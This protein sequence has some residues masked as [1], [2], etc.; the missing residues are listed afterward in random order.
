VERDGIQDIDQRSILD[1]KVFDDIEG[2]DFGVAGDG[3]WKVPSEGWSGPSLTACS[4]EG[5]AAFEDTSNGPD[6][7]DPAKL[8]LEQFSVNSQGSIL[9]E[10]TVDLQGSSQV[11]DPVF[12]VG[13]GSVDGTGRTC[14]VGREIDTVQTLRSRPPDPMLDRGQAEA[15]LSGYR[16]HG[17]TSAYGMDDALALL[18]NGLFLTIGRSPMGSVF[19]DRIASHWSPCD[20]R[21]LTLD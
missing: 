13:R 10:V 7:G 19:E 18:F 8:G 12:Q 6:R 9:S 21:M 17:A 4:I 15:E 5:S 16:P 11:Q 1:A 14:G 2:I 20:L 3:L